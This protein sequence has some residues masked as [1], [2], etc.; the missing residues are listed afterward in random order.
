M[1]KKIR[2]G[3]AGAMVL[4]ATGMIMYILVNII[5][6]MLVIYLV[7]RAG[8]AAY[9]FTYQVFGSVP[10]TTE[11]EAY[12]EKITITKGESTMQFSSEL[13]AKKLIVNRLSFYVRAQLTRRNIY[14][15]TYELSSAMD[16][17]EILD[18]IST[19]HDDEN[20]S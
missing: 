7:A 18:I 9:Q 2:R 20:E 3:K 5:F 15:G 12:T 14:P 16:Y 10:M 1:A 13:E 19:P 4:D 11:K 6:Y 17:D 8:K